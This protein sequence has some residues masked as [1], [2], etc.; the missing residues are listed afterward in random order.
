L[1]IDTT[2]ILESLGPARKFADPSGPVPGRM[3]AASGALPIPAEQIAVVLFCLSADP[4]E[5]VAAKAS[6]SL[7][8]LPDNVLETAIKAP[9]PGAVLDYFARR[10]EKNATHLE[11]IALNPAT[12]DETYCFLATLPHPTIVDIV[13]RNQTRLLR[14]PELVEAL[15]ENP[16]TGGATIDRVLEFLGISGDEAEEEA[17]SNVLEV[18]EPLDSTEAEGA[19]VFDPDD[20][21]GL[22]EELMVDDD[23]DNDDN[24][25]DEFE[26]P[27]E[28]KMISLYAQIQ[29]MNVMEKVKLARFGNGDARALLVRDRNKVVCTAAIRSPKIK[30]SEVATF[31]KARNL[32]DEI[33]RI[34][35][36]TRDWTKSYQVKL[37]LATNPKTPLSS[38]MKFVSYLTDRDLRG[39]MRSREVPGQISAQAR[40]ILAKKGKI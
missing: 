31:A 24:D 4:D 14:S 22:P 37:S 21:K 20:I 5:A 39:I 35:A 15:S 2:L 8:N 19:E 40:R 36:N 6:A 1:E 30:A 10:F 38:A 12:A 26:E 29:D 32:S 17:E 7:V 13:S 16:V 23:D 3:M 25:D 11:T 33:L 34:I 9:L 18:P 27:D 28:E